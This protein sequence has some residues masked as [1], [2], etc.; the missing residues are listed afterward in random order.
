MQRRDFINNIIVAAAAIPLA[1]LGVSASPAL[2][3]PALDSPALDRRVIYSRHPIGC[4]KPIYV[5]YHK[6]GWELGDLVEI[7]GGVYTIIEILGVQHLLLDRP[8]ECDCGSDLKYTEIKVIGKWEWR[9][10]STPII[11]VERP[12]RTCHR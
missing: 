2:D 4:S 10:P 6:H 5:S 8:L 3:S 9:L 12:M 1:S 7:N 11:L